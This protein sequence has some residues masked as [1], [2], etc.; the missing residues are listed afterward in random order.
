VVTF[1]AEDVPIS[2]GVI[3]DFSGACPTKWV[4]HAKPPVQFF[5][6]ANQRTSFSRKLP[7]SGGINEFLY[8]QRGRPAKPHDAH[9]PKAALRF[10]TRST[11]GLSQM[12]GAHNAKTYLAHLIG[13]RIITAGT[14]KATL[15]GW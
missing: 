13:W 10:S 1:S 4:R 2:I 15:S 11:L 9:A 5:K 12:R 3:F 7:T 14:T 8:E 6:T